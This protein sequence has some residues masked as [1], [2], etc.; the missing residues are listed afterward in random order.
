V[1]AKPPTLG[2]AEIVEADA[3]LFE[4]KSAAPWSRGSLPPS[5]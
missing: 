2:F 1:T 5:V 4:V 3:E